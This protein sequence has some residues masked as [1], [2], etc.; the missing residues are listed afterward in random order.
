MY[1]EADVLPGGDRCRS[2]APV[3]KAANISCHACFWR[4]G[5]WDIGSGKMLFTYEY[6][7]DIKMRVPFFCHWK[8]HCEKMRYL[9]LFLHYLTV[10]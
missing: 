10:I 5:C 8:A 9:N 6:I 7:N 3:E 2:C 4:P 1:T